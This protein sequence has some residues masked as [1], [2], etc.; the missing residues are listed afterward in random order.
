MKMSLLMLK[1]CLLTVL[2]LAGV[3]LGIYSQDPS[4]K[5]RYT[6]EHPLVYTDAWDLWPYVFLDESGNPTGYN[7]ELLKMIFE[8]L[9]IPYEIH[10]KPTERALEDLFEGR[11]TLMLGMVASFHDR[12]RVSYGKNV[13]QLFTHSVAHPREVPATV[14]GLEDLSKEQVI[15]HTGSFSHH[16]MIPRVGRQCAAPGR[17]GQGH[18]AGQHRGARPGAVEHHVAEVAHV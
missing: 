2:L 13:I 9:D 5:S 4:L 14:H 18:P 10:L 1:R 12:E 8:E 3:S 15:V 6:Q 17:H 7:V 11:A 16:L